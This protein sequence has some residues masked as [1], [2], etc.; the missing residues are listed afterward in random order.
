MAF[1]CGP[2]HPGLTSWVILSRPC[3]TDRVVNPYPG[4]PRISCTLLWTRLR[5]AA[6]FTESRTKLSHFTKLHRKSGS[7]L[8][9]SQPSLRD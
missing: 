1:T 5:Y 2:V 3:G 8:G 9:Y 6:F 7:V 4:L